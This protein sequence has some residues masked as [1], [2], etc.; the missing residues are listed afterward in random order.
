MS[1]PVVINFAGEPVAKGRPRFASIG[2]K[3]IAYTPTKTRKYE[4]A[5]QYAARQAMDGRPLLTGPVMMSVVVSLPVPTSWSGKQQKAALAG[6]VMPTK[7]P[8]IDNYIKVA[9]DALNGVVFPDDN[10]ITFL[11]ASKIYAEKPNLRI[12]VAM[13]G[14]KT[15]D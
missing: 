3:P 2:G 14:N 5:L 4:A 9:C 1:D 12:E 13:F 6:N 7:R 10:Q 11:T 15:N 8:D